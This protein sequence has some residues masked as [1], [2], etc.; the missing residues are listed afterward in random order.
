MSDESKPR[1]RTA[2]RELALFLVLVFAGLVILPILIYLVGRALF[3]E[4]SGFGFSDFYA[5]LHA[6]LRAGEPVV[7]FLMLSPYVGWQLLR[8]TAYGFRRAGK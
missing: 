7:W 4:Y 1:K 2:V 8:L 3:G 5:S 6:D